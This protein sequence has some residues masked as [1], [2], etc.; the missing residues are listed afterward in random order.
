MSLT[1]QQIDSNYIDQVFPV[2]KSFI[3]AG[4]ENTDSCTV[5]DAKAF[6]ERGDWQL[7][8]AFDEKNVISGAYV[9]T[10][11]YEPAGKIAIIISAGGKGLASQEVFEQACNIFKSFGAI[12][13][14]ALASDSGARLFNRVGLKK[15]ANLVEKT[16]WAE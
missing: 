9:T 16:L 13:V 5:E 14:Q 11:N 2:V 6:L 7:L 1:V 12:K 4:L 3:A 15:K 8:V 10:Y